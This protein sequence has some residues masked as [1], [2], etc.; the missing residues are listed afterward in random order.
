M[1]TTPVLRREPAH[2]VVAGVCAGLARVW[3]ID[4]LLVRLAFVISTLVTTGLG[5]FAYLALWMLLPVDGRGDRGPGRLAMGLV[6]AC[7]LVGVLS[8]VI[9]PGGVLAAALIFGV[10]YF[11]GRKNARAQAPTPASTPAEPRTEFERLSLLWHERMTDVEQGRPTGSYTSPYFTQADPVGLYTTEA[12]VRRGPDRVAR[13]QLGARTWLGVLVGWGA[14]GVGLGVASVWLPV[15]PVAWVAGALLV[16]GLALLAAAR[17]R[18]AAFGRPPGM[19]LAGAALSVATLVMAAPPAVLPVLPSATSVSHAKASTLPRSI[20]LTGASA[21]VNLA[22]MTVDATVTTSVTMD[23][24]R[25]VIDLPD[26]GNYV[27]HWSVDAGD[28][29]TPD[30]RH[31]GM[32]VTGTLSRTPRPGQPVVTVDVR[33]DVGSLELR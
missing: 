1:S 10:F 13:R 24:G 5:L 21:T 6:A 16:V 17:P 31:N 12:P 14:V 8:S 23:V 11:I 28:V 15:P 30:G 2:G 26:H 27:V 4:P 20:D 22:A 33:L 32:D 3:N 29:V 18:R 9:N 7:A 25:L 19:L